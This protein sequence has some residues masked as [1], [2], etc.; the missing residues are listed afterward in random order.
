MDIQPFGERVVIK[1]VAPEEK[2]G[3]LIVATSK[4]K[5][6]RGEVVAVGDEVKC[7]IQV[8]DTVLFNISS[9]VSYSTGTDDYK[10]INIKDILGKI[11]KEDK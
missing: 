1:V 5:S 4:D 3:A 10:I 2:V 8:G 6:N 7:S 9:G 11:I